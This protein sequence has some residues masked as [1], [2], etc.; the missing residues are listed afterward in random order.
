MKLVTIRHQDRR[1]VGAIRPG[2]SVVLLEDVLGLPVD[3]ML[4]VLPDI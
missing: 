2:E 1:K 3:D 4:S